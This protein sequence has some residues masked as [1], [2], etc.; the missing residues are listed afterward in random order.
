MKAI[1]IRDFGGPEVLRLEDVPT[2]NPGPGEVLI[3][4]HAVS[5]NRT[6]DL[7]VRAG[8]Y[9]MPITLPHVLGVDPSGII[10]AVGEGV[11][12]RKPGDRVATTFIIRAPTATEGMLVLGVHVWGGYAEYVK[13]PAHVTYIVPDALDFPTATVVV[14]HAPTAL[15]LLRDEA[16]LKPGEWILVMGATGG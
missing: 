13:V 1:V 16:R 7:V 14:R 11:S 3:Q 9:A 8:K 12:T 6:L 5:V 15:A 4:V 2:P 10:A